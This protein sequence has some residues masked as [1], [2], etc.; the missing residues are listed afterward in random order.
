LAA[1]GHDEPRFTVKLGVDDGLAWRILQQNALKSPS[2]SM[3]RAPR[4]AQLLLRGGTRMVLFVHEARVVNAG[5][6][7][8]ARGRQAAA[9]RARRQQRWRAAHHE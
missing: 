3:R 2:D 6:C 8:H 4:Q 7:A 5:C 9:R 1:H